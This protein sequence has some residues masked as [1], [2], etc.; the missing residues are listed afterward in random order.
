M[1]NTT[2]VKQSFMLLFPLTATGSLDHGSKEST[3]LTEINEK[4]SKSLPLVLGHDHYAGDI[5]L[6]LAQL[7]LRRE[8]QIKYV[9]ALLRGKSLHLPRPC[10]TVH[11]GEPKCWGGS[12]RITPLLNNQ[13]VSYRQTI[14]SR[15][16]SQLGLYS[17]K[18]VA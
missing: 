18:P 11:E 6:L 3:S 2:K 8:K 15:P 10:T 13:A 14:D 4:P 12:S 1:I 16:A 17:R 5:I 7:F 9:R